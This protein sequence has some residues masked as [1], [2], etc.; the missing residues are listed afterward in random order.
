MNEHDSGDATTGIE[1]VVAAIPGGRLVAPGQMD[2]VFQVMPWRVVGS[3]EWIH[4]RLELTVPMDVDLADAWLSSASPG[5]GLRVAEAVPTPT[6]DG[7]T[8]RGV[9]V[10]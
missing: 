9:R 7:W 5:D 4:E 3:V 6:S 10:D 1:G 8:A 2:V